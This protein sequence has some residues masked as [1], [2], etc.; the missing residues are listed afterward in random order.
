MHE[1]AINLLPPC[2]K[3]CHSLSLSRCR[4][5]A[6]PLIVMQECTLRRRTF[7]PKRSV[8]TSLHS[9]HSSFSASSERTT[10]CR[11]E[12]RSQSHVCLFA[13]SQCRFQCTAFIPIMLNACRSHV[14]D[15]ARMC[16]WSML[17]GR[18]PPL[19][20]QCEHARPLFFLLFSSKHNRSKSIFTY[21]SI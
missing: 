17:C 2:A 20:F 6:L 9:T 14:S 3:T 4:T 10:S 16:V 11:A 13:E 12:L 21:T 18:T 8:A 5:L 19:S 15:A 7:S 1:C